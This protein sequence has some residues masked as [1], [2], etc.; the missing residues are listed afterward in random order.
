MCCAEQ[1]FLIPVGGISRG[2]AV[3]SDY[4]THPSPLCLQS[5]SPNVAPGSR[6]GGGAGFFFPVF[7]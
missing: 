4:K 5:Y 3:F 1:T 6:E 7:L 2:T